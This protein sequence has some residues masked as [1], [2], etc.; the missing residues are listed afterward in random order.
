MLKLHMLFAEGSSSAPAQLVAEAFL[1]HSS[2]QRDFVHILG[3]KLRDHGLR[4]FSSSEADT[5]C[6]QGQPFD[7][8]LLQHVR[9]AKVVVLVLSKEFFGSKWCVRE[10]AEALAVQQANPAKILLPVFYGWNRPED[11][12]SWLKQQQR[13]Q[14]KQQQQQQQQYED[15]QQQQQQEGL[16]DDILPWYASSWHQLGDDISRIQA[17]THQPGSTAVE[18]PDRVMSLVQ[19]MWKRVSTIHGVIFQPDS[20]TVELADRVLSLVLP[21]IYVATFPEQCIVSAGSLVEWGLEHLKQQGGRLGIT[22]MGGMGKTTLA[23]LLFNR[24]HTQF[25]G[26][27][28]YIEVRVLAADP[29]SC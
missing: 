3:G 12:G 29:C 13:H 26:R 2:K 10:L 8:S 6:E 7:Q 9:T 15:K 11:L 16:P 27:V 4:Y 17:T 25:E 21:H 14:E 18:L 28:A 23:Q 22:G 5:G 19:Q 20:N 1:S 24:L